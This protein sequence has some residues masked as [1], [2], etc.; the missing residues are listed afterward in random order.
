MI[1]QICFARPLAACAVSN[2]GR[3]FTVMFMETMSAVVGLNLFA[4]TPGSAPVQVIVT[5]PSWAGAWAGQRMQLDPGE[6]ARVVVP[7][8]LINTANQL[9]GKGILV[10]ASSDIALYAFSTEQNSCGGAVITPIVALGSE[11]YAVVWPPNSQSPEEYSQLGVAAPYA[12]TTVTFNFLADSRASVSYDGN[13][14]DSNTPLTVE[15]GYMEVFTLLERNN[16]DLTGTKISSNQPIAVFSGNNYVSVSYSGTQDMTLSQLTPVSTWGTEYALAPFPGRSVGDQVRII[17]R[18]AQTTIRTSIANS[19]LFI[20]QPGGFVNLEIQSDQPL[21]L[22]SS[23]PFFV[24]QFAKSTSLGDQGQPVM[25]SMPPVSQFRN[26]YTFSL[27]IA[28]EYNIFLTFYSEQRFVSGL[29]LDGNPVSTDRWQTIPGFPQTF[30]YKAIQISPGYHS[31]FISLP[32]AVFGATVYGQGGRNCGFSYPVGSCYQDQGIVRILFFVVVKEA[33][34]C[35]DTKI[36]QNSVQTQ[37]NTHLV[38]FLSFSQFRQHLPF[39]VRLQLWK[40][41]RGQVRNG[42]MR[43]LLTGITKDFAESS[44]LQK[45]PLIKTVSCLLISDDCQ[46]SNMGRQFALVFLESIR[47][48]LTLNIFAATASS[49][50]VSVAVSTPARGPRSFYQTE[51]LFG[52]SMKQTSIP[53]T[54]QLTGSSRSLNGILITASA[55]VVVSGFNMD[56]TSCG[57]FLLYP[58]N[59]LGS[60]YY[61]MNWWPPSARAQIGIVATQD[62]TIVEVQFKGNGNVVVFEGRTY[63]SGSKMRITLGSFQAAQIQDVSKADLTGTYITADKPIAVFSGNLFTSVPQEGLIIRDQLI[64]QMPPTTTYGSEFI[65]VPIPESVTG[66][67]LEVLALYDNTAVQASNTPGFTL[68]SAGDTAPIQITAYTEITA[69]KALLVAQ[70]VNSPRLSENEDDQPA[71]LLIPPVSQ[72]KQD[73]TFLVATESSVNYL[74]IVILDSYQDGLLLDGV[75]VTTAW[76]PVASSSYVGTYVKIQGGQHRLVHIYLNVPF[77]AYIYGI[78][79]DICAYAYS[80]GTCLIPISPV[81]VFKCP[82]FL[83]KKRQEF[84]F[85]GNELVVISTLK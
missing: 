32:E 16:L 44:M 9:S 23:K 5:A 49:F 72:F 30:V 82:P 3:R 10:E 31:A 46:V 81:S 4:V 8:S 85:L 48:N 57:G 62:N 12:A 17:A 39:P 21:R 61:T 56:S 80:A 36:S 47:N 20:E 18:D 2:Y 15:L 29:V 41:R 59:T 27:P 67:V 13:T 22:T 66:S 28:G 52:T 77:G 69:D 83:T 42:F 71:M 65:V 58:I 68:A 6:S 43:F 60:S 40:F 70:Y 54:L 78:S 84:S 11:Y 55:D 19:D 34:N 45:P 24:A 14:Y 74:M 33:N 50:P 79:N 73:Y 26:E 38:S 51:T 63:F 7:T 76:T 53:N 64:E 1:V 75:P 37:K 35:H 25:L